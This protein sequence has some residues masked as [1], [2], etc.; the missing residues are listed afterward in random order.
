MAPP[1]LTPSL[2]PGLTPKDGG[3]RLESFGDADVER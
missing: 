3:L 1:G 2:T